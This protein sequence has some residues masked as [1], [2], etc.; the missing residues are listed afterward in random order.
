M[1]IPQKHVLLFC[2]PTWPPCHVV[3]NQELNFFPVLGFSFSVTLF[4]NTPHVYLKAY[5][6]LVINKH[7]ANGLFLRVSVDS[8]SHSSDNTEPPV[9]WGGS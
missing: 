5:L 1:Q 9:I 6:S 4:S 8:A 2:Q 3:A 7:L